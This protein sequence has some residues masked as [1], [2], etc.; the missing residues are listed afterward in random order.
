MSLFRRFHTA[1]A[2]AFCGLVLSSTAEARGGVILLI[3]PRPI[4][5][6]PVYRPPPPPLTQPGWTPP[7]PAL[8]P[9]VA[10]PRPRCYAG[11]RVC[12]LGRSAMPGDTCTCRAADR[13]LAGR[14]LIPPSRHIGAVD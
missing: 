1:L 6:E 4:I 13:T 8:V 9:R 10:P 14:A 11:V 12:V 7:L 2:V 5:P 3:V